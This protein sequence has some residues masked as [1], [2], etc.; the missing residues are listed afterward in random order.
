MKPVLHLRF[1][2]A[3]PWYFRFASARYRPAPDLRESKHFVLGFTLGHPALDGKRRI[4]QGFPKVSVIMPVHDCAAFVRRDG[5]IAL[6]AADLRD[7]FLRPPADL[8]GLIS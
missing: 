8:R 2:T 7:F 6:V 4:N 3:L 1:E 5:V